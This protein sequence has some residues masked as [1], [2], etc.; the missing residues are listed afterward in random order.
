MSDI[1]PGLFDT[2]ATLPASTSDEIAKA[3]GLNERYVREW[4][5]AMTVGRFIEYDPSNHTYVLPPEHAVSLTRASGP[6]NMA[7]MAQFTSLMGGVE[8]EIVECF[9]VGGG[10]PYSR[11]PKFQELMAEVSGRV[12]DVALIDGTLPFVDGLIDRL[13]E[14]IDVCDIG[15]GQGHAVNLMAKEFPNSRFTGLDFS[16]GGHCRRKGRGGE[17]GPDQCDVRGE[18]RGDARRFDEVRPHHGVRRSARSGQ[19]GRRAEGHR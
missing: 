17:V 1:A 19:A 8:D 11:F 2:M 10:V 18:G 3:A 12:H 15:C 13:R 9:R 14:G 7:N 6:G 4:L 5:N 16:R